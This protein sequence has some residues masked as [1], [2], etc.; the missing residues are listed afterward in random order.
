MAAAL[1]DAEPMPDDGALPD[2]A[3]AGRRQRPFG[4]YVHV[5]FCASRCGY[6]DFNTYTADQLP[7]ASRDDYPDLVLAE[8]AQARR[9]LGAEQ[10]RYG[11]CSSVAAPP[12]CCRPRRW[13][14]SWPASTP[15]S[16]WRRTPR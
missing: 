13:P 3:L 7:G 2:A 12:P 14:G 5:P 1:P 9:V 15:R 11:R 8:L 6:C 10:P 4:I 16:G